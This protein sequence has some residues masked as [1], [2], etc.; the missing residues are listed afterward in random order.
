M[1]SAH[2]YDALTPDVILAAVETVGVHCTGA[3]IALNSYENRVYRVDTEEHGPWAVKFYRPGRWSNAA[4]LEEHEFA[5][6]LAEHEIPAIAPLAHA[7]QT[8]H[9]Y[10]GFRFALLPWQPGRA[11]ELTRAEDF[12]M[13]GRYLGRLHAVSSATPFLYRPRLNVADFGTRSVAMLLDG[14]FIPPDLRTAFRAICD[15]VL[16]PVAQAF[17]ALRDVDWLALHGDFH[18]GNILWSEHGPHLV[19]FDDCLMGPAV[20]DL[21][22]ILSGERADMERSLADLL[23]GYTQ[24]AAFNPAELRLIEPLRTLRILRY[25]AWLADRW[26]DPAFPRNFPWFIGPRYWEEQILILKQ[27]ASALDEPPLEWAP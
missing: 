16:V 23:S 11:P 5:L 19:D 27:Q 22:M 14:D 24:F 15:Q 20:Q 2:P 13:L 25:N 7:G 12:R 3:F 1:H 26:Q 18:L 9:E 4:I 17:E 10:H 8:L 6:G 21:W